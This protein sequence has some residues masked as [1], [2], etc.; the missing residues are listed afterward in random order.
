[1]PPSAL[2]S[3][4]PVFRAPL[5]PLALAWGAGI[6][7]GSTLAP[8]ALWLIAGA[9]ALLLA[10]AA[11]LALR[12][13]AGAC[14]LLLGAT[15]ALGALR[16][17]EQPPPPGS[18]AAAAI[19]GAMAVESQIVEEPRRWAPDRARLLLDVDAVVT[20]TERRPAPGR[21]LVTLYGE[22]PPLGEG[23]R[24]AA[25]LRLHR[26]VGFRNPGGFDYSAQLRREGI[27]LVGSGRADRVRPLTA[28]APPWPARVKR[29]AVARIGAE[30][31]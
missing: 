29:W 27:A 2:A 28:D 4:A 24:I 17:H 31:P 8:P 5:V 20:D 16:A 15:A 13:T 25:D 26:P 14:A 3:V 18:I 10:A 23:Q 6:A 11:G 1:M 9:G 22:A 12:H 7:A 21:V 19:D 30:L